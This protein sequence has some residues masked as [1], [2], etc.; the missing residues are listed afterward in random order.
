MTAPRRVNVERMR[1]RIS[2]PRP[3][4]QPARA[5]EGPDPIVVKDAAG[6]VIRVI[7]Q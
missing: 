2:V 6:N 1:K 3:V 7:E 5:A 4:E